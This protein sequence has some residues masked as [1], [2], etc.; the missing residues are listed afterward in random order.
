MASGEKKKMKKIISIDTETISLKDKTILAI[1]VSDGSRTIV[2]PV[3]MNTTKNFITVRVIKYIEDL[4]KDCKVIFHNSSFDI[5]ALV[6][7]GVSLDSFIDIEDTVIISQLLDENIRHGLKSLTKR[8]FHHTMKEYKEVCGTGKKQI[9][10]AD[11]PWDEAKEY[12]KQ[13]AYWTYK[14]YEYLYPKLQQEQKLFTIYEI[15]ERPLLKVVSDMHINGINI[16]TDKVKEISD[17]CKENIDSIEERLTIFL[18]KD[19]N[20]NSSKQLK[21]YFID[22]LGKEILKKSKITN[23]PSVDKEVLEKYAEKDPVA[24]LILEYRKYKKIYS[25]FIPALTPDDWDLKTKTGKI[26]ASFNQAGT[27]SGRFSSSSPNMQNIPREKDEYGIRETII[28]DKEQILVGADYSQIELR[29]L[30]HVSQDSNLLKAYQEGKD[31]HKM[32]ADACGITRDE[33][34]RVNFG[35]A[36]GM[37]IKTLGKT[38]NKSYEEA[39]KYIQKY[40]ETYPKVIEFWDNAKKCIKEKGFVETVMGRK[41]RRSKEFFDKDSY[42]QEMEIR[43]MT[44]HIIQGSAADLIKIAMVDMYPKL[45]NMGARIVLSVHDEVIIS[46]SKDKAQKTKEII[47]NSMIKAGK[48]LTVP[49]EVD[50]KFGNTWADTHGEGIDIEEETIDEEE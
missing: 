29:V 49:V 11:V 37:G 32:T 26:Y 41:R 17:L 14:L 27:V 18:G 30:A 3:R 47:Y 21:E 22:K 39:E 25:T 31:I 2:L 34:K 20:I 43:S 15:I 38:I 7:L 48:I 6:L 45:K 24:K 42:E 46:V 28:A 12:S 23:E 33:A 16:N 5:P 10:F 40:H 4:L 8:Y 50:I 44:N 1:S 36:Y 35:I 19:F 13:D 9:S